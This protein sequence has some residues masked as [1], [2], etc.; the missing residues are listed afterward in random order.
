[1]SKISIDNVVRV[2]LLSALKGLGNVN[3]SALAII[4][5]EV[6]ISGNY[7]VSRTYLD[8]ITVSDDFGSNSETFRLALKIFGQSPNIITGGGYLVI[9]PRSQTATAKTASILGSDFINLANLTATDYSINANVD[10]GGASDIVI[11]TIDT[12][13]ISTVLTSL[14]NTAITN[15]GL[16]FSI[17]GEYASAKITLS[18]TATGITASIVIATVE[19]GTD[20]TTDLKIS[21]S[22][23]G[24]DAGVERIKDAILRTAGAI[25]YFGIVFNEKMADATLIETASLVQTLDKIMF[26]GSNLQADIDGVFKTIKDSGLTHTRC[27][28]YTGNDSSNALDFAS[29]YAS[30]ALST[31]FQGSNTAQTMHLKEIVGLVADEN[32]NQTVLD[33]AKSNGVDVYADFGVPKL[34]TSGAN[35]YFDQ[36]YNRLALKVYL[37]IAGFNFLATVQTKI[38]QTEEGMNALKSAYRNICSQFIINNV[39]SAGKW[40]SPITYGTSPEDHIRNIKEQGYFI[41]S[42]PIS[43]QNQTERDARKAPLIQIAF[44][45]SGAIH[46][47][48]VTIFVEA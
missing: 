9:I 28:L 45:E 25:N 33:L 26:V 12:T 43:Q 3:T 35:S 38:P 21:G 46:S 27:L 36:V 47:S 5:D 20:I 29:G 4:T 18:T 10:G 37:Q 16:V 1:M 13:D 14:N 32:L 22:A 42:Q 31:N 39:G 19:T 7:G 15:A 41:Y 30:R 34:F 40:N 11:G 48:D 2:S 24:A 8:P 17:S 44:K 23:T 6:P